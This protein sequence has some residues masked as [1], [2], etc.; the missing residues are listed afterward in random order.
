M[1]VL[2]ISTGLGGL[3]GFWGPWGSGVYPRPVSRS[4]QPGE[5][6]L[7]EHIRRLAPQAPSKTLRL[8]IGDDC[9]ILAPPRGHEILVTTDFSLENRHFRRD[10]HSPRSIGHRTLARGLSDVAAM[11]AAPVAAFLSLALPRK[12]ASSQAWID[13]FF[14]G[15]LALAAAHKV[16][17]AGGD[18]SE[19][20]SSEILVD[21]VLL[22]SAPPGRALRRS[23]ARPGDLLYVTGS[24][25][26]AAA[27]LAALAANPR[28]FRNAAPADP[29]PHLFPQPRLAVGQALLRRRLATACIDVSDGLSTDL[30]HLC[31]ESNV[32]AE[33]DASALPL[34]GSIEQALH[35]G[36]DYELL[37]TAGPDTRVP[38]SIAGTPITPIGRIASSR[39]NRPL[40]TL[41]EDSNRR[42]HFHK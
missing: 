8:G 32:S 20:P 14:G 10:W 42:P 17:L 40:I 7:I 9:A 6:S 38:R 31:S 36:E 26:G 19:S 11:G 29:H 16:Q 4:L 12:V 1:R 3:T 23:T 15:L 41:I 24:L 5:L 30:A 18:T 37:F 33:L 21:I 22:G 25:G 28:R 2:A 27:E 34:A 13:G 39:R 35:G